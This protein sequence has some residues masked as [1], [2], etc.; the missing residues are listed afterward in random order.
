MSVISY[1]DVVIA[2]AGPVGLLLACELRLGGASVLV[3]E[4]ETSP[5]NA[6]KALPFG[7]R[8][9]AAPSLAALSR[10]GL[11]NALMADQDGNPAGAHWQGQARAVA[12][13]F[14]GIP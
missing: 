3:L 11:L 5:A 8:G 14:A 10:R 12:G 4:R 2:G 1:Y 7:M 9:L 6:L 13:H